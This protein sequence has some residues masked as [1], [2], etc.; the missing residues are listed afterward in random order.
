MKIFCIGR[1]YV[2]HA[3]EMNSPVPTSPMVFMKPATSVCKGDQVPYPSFTN[4]L[5]YE[6]EVLLFVSKT[7]TNVPVDKA[8]EYIDGIGLGIDFT[9]RDIQRKCKEKGHPWEKAKAFDNSAVISQKID[10]DKYALKALDFELKL[11]DRIVQSGNT[12]DLIFDFETLI[13]HIS[14]YFTLEAGDVI[15][16]GTPAGVGPVQPGDELRAFVGDDL[17]LNLSIIQ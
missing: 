4:D 8:Y 17:Y 3:K 16:T 7:G 1:N 11:N 13:S 10:L 15:F 2:D 14:E 6:L 12:R 9:A 5:H